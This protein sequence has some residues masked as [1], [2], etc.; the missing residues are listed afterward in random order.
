MGIGLG[1]MRHCLD[2]ILERLEAGPAGEDVDHA[3]E[4]DDR[5]RLGGN[6]P[7]R[8]LDGTIRV[9]DPRWEAVHSRRQPRAAWRF[10]P[11]SK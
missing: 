1:G 9:V 5:L 2:E 10:Y 7:F 3:D 11:L 4:V 6:A 8:R